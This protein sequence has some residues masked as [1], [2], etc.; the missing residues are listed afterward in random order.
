MTREEY[1]LEALR[2]IADPEHCLTQNTAEGLRELARRTLT[3]LEEPLDCPKGGKHLMVYTGMV[4]GHVCTK[5]RV[6]LSTINRDRALP[7]LGK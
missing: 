4:R 6:S 2:A 7:P 3:A 1:A 5:C